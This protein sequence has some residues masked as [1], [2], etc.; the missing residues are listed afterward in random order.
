MQIAGPTNNTKHYGTHVIGGIRDHISVV[1][2]MRICC[3]LPIVNRHQAR[4][5][6]C[7]DSETWPGLNAARE[8]SRLFRILDVSKKPANA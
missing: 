1:I 5:G 3:A 4:V 7:L 6:H 8:S 2:N